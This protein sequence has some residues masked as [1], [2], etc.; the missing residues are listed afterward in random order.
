MALL[1]ILTFPD[2]RLREKARDVQVFDADLKQLAADMVETMYA[3]PGVGLAAT[4][5]GVAKRMV[6]VDEYAGRDGSKGPEVYVNPQLVEA[7]G[8]IICE[9]GCL[10]LPDFSEEVKR[11]DKIHVRYQ[12]LEGKAR[13]VSLEGF[14]AVILQHEMDHLEGV[15]AVDRVSRLKRA[16]YSKRRSRSGRNSKEEDVANP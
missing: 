6:V 12:D 3:A 10:S 9:E 2:P 5:V 15:L 11:K 4:Q 1:R 8:E 14:H 16:L 7:S 13:E